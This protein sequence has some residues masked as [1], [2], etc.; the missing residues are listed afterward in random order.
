MGPRGADQLV[1]LCMVGSLLDGRACIRPALECRASGW[2]R[3]GGPT[4][5]LARRA[6]SGVG[7]RGVR[8]VGL[9]AF[10][11]FVAGRGG[12][13]APIGNYRRGPLAPLWKMGIR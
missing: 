4:R 2:R 8:P 11:S 1:A 6:G 7:N 9:R 13:R 12:R 10:D 3:A 5:V